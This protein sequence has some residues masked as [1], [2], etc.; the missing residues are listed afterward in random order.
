MPRAAAPSL[1]TKQLQQAFGVAHM[2]VYNWRQGTATKDALPFTLE[3]P[4]AVKPRVRFPLAKIKAWAKRNGVPFAVEP[5]KILAKADDRDGKPGPK[6]R[7][8]VKH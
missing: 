2:T 5:E 6:P 3:N 7:K 4:D 1:T 8:R